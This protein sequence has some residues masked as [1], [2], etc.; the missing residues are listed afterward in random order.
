MGDSI[1]YWSPL[2]AGWYV[3]GHLKRILLLRPDN[4]RKG[5]AG[6]EVAEGDDLRFQ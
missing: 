4:Y 1:I 6:R 5:F 2:W 3:T